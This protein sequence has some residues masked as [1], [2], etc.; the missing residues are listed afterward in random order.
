M[1]KDQTVITVDDILDL[2]NEITMEPYSEE[3]R[4]DYLHDLIYTL[5]IVCD[6]AVTEDNFGFSGAHTRTGKRI[7]KYLYAGGELFED[8]I[9][10][11]E[12]SLP[13][14]FNTQLSFVDKGYF[15]QC[16]RLAFNKAIERKEFWEKRKKAQ[17]EKEKRELEKKLEIVEQFSALVIKRKFTNIDTRNIRSDKSFIMS[18][19]SYGKKR[20]WSIKQY[21]FVKKFVAMYCELD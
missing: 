21:E 15:K 3:P 17:E 20:T 6:G 1:N 7:A 13:Y 5:D 2:E 10:W 12:K 18:L 19:Q 9:E 4:E 16:C 11:I 8:Q 14:Y